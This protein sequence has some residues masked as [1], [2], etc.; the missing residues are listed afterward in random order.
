MT[1]GIII[2]LIAS[3]IR[4]WGLLNHR[5]GPMDAAVIA[6]ESVLSI[7]S[8]ISIVMG[9]VGAFLIG[10]DTSLWIGIFVFVGFWFL[11][12]IWAP[13]LTAFGL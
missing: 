10:A 1:A 9:L 2:L 6:S 8:I 3:I 12:G 11:S 13:I 5:R 7:L 4:G